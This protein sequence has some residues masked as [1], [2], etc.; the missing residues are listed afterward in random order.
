MDWT[1]VEAANLS[2]E[3]RERWSE[4]LRQQPI[5][6]VPAFH[7]EFVCGLAQY[8]PGCKVAILRRGTSVA[9]YL[10]FAQTGHGKVAGPIPMCDYQPIILARDCH[11]DA[12]ATLRA[13]G[14]RSWMFENVLAQQLP[15][16]QATQ[17]TITHSLRVELANGFDTYRAELKAAGKSGRHVQ[18][19][20]RLLRRD[21]GRIELIHNIADESA[22]SR[23]LQFKAAR[24]A[25]NGQFPFWVREALAHFQQL[26]SGPVTGHLSILKAGQQEVAYVFYLKLNELL[27]FWFPTFNPLFRKYSPG[28][29]AL[30]LLI[31]DMDDLRCSTID[32]GPGGEAYKA[33]FANGQ[34]EIGCGRVDASAVVAATRRIFRHLK[35]SLRP[36]QS[37]IKP[38]VRLLRR[39]RAGG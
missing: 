4:L 10:P 7:P 5:F 14:L 29:L 35:Q 24:Y 34:I 22:L 23:L 19:N 28:M 2:D 33:Y 9:G 27:Y 11:F 17:L 8:I 38:A 36:A 18:N 12:R 39:S 25:P 3:H 32:L 21:H 30:W 6:D 26:Q 16:D 20:I 31:A 13:L 1:I 15:S 37:Y